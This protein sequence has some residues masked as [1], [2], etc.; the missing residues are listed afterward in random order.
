MV[1]SIL[2]LVLAGSTRERF[3]GGILCQHGA[4][5]AVLHSREHQEQP[6]QGVPLRGGGESREYGFSHGAAKMVTM[7]VFEDGVQGDECG[8]GT[9]V[10]EG[11]RQGYPFRQH[12]P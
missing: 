6:A 9:V 8:H 4:N 7:N 3:G 2:H 5:R 10:G 12:V 1:A 11:P